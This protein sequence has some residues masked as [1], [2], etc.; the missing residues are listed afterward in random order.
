MSTDD[1]SRLNDLTLCHRIIDEQSETIA[2]LQTRLAKMEH[3]LEQLIR[4]KYGSRAEKIDAK[5]LSLFDEALPD[6]RPK[7]EQP[8]DE[9]I[10]IKEHRR[11]SG[12]RNRLP[13]DLPREVIEHDLSDVEKLC[14][15][16]G[17]AR[18][19]IGDER[20]EQLEFVPAQLKILEHV[21]F[22]YACRNCEEHVAIA[23][24]PAKPI[25]KGLPGPGL[26]AAL[27]VGKYTDHLPLYRLEDVFARSGVELSRST[28]CRWVRET[29]ELFRPL[30]DLMCRRVCSSA[31]IHTDDTP[32]RVQD[33][34]LPRT[35]TGRF[36]VYVGDAD[37][38]YS[39]YAYTPSRKR[40]GPAKFLAGYKGYLHA[41]AFAGYDGIYVS[42]E[43]KQVLC[44]AHA[45]RKF[46]EARTAQPVLA[47]AALAYIG[48]LY[49]VERAAKR[50][51]ETIDLPDR[52]AR[53]AWYA[54]RREMRQTESLPILAELRTWLQG[55]QLSVLPKSPLGGAI[56]YVLPRWEAFERYCEDGALSID[57]N[58]SERTLRPCAI[59]RKNWLFLGNDQGGDSAA[60]HYSLVASCKAH[61]LDPLAYLRELLITIPTLPRDEATGE[62]TEEKLA[63]LLPDEWSKT[64]P[65][66]HRTYAR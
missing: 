16:C 55:I 19:R 43:V 34:N 22:K 42:G 38:P 33:R 64:N 14:P 26:L 36:W 1:S 20:S 9:S 7:E 60:M 11:G 61:A 29:A 45:R 53:Q 56:G 62:P 58:L 21:R 57:N 41:D 52:A 65:Q 6:E 51:A 44:W 10:L 17:R 37:H 46:F 2:S 39:V 15:C 31:A 32:V 66:A 27:I 40:D 4:A 24:P 3:Q 54:Q 5:Q 63:P 30:Y 59:G 28:L 48:R 49:D 25:G 12:G 23:P 13:D 8:P 47:H 18:I 35:R 50:L